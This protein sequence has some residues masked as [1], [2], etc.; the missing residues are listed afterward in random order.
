MPSGSKPNRKGPRVL[1]LKQ[2]REATEGQAELRLLAPVPISHRQGPGKAVTTGQSEELETREGIGGQRE[3]T[4][5]SL[6]CIDNS[7]GL[8]LGASHPAP[9]HLVQG[10]EPGVNS[11]DVAIPDN[12]GA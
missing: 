1:A 12:S 11:Y 6:P 7:H 3:V 10:M 5:A 9:Q 4:T 2:F 8:G